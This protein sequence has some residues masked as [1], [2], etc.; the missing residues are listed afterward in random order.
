MDHVPFLNRVKLDSTTNEKI[1][2]ATD[3]LSE[4][5]KS[6]CFYQMFYGY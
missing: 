6:M 1:C 2:L 4:T 3:Q 5:K